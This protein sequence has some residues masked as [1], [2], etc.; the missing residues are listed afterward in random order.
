MGI[1]HS[2]YLLRK[3]Y[4]ETIYQE[5][6]KGNHKLYINILKCNLSII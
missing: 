2:H 3:Y 4:Q 5:I 6:K 1:T